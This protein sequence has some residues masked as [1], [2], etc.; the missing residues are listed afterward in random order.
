MLSSSTVP[1]LAVGVDF[2]V[3]I[4]IATETPVPKFYADQFEIKICLLKSIESK[5]S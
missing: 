3:I 1:K 4:N 2:V 5:K